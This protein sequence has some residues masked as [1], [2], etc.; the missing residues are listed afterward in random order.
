M[1]IATP[2]QT[3][4]LEEPSVSRTSNLCFRLISSYSFS[5]FRLSCQT[6]TYSPGISSA[7]PKPTVRKGPQH[8]LFT[9]IF[10]DLK[11]NFM[12]TEVTYFNGK[13]PNEFLSQNCNSSAIYALMQDLQAKAQGQHQPNHKP[14]L[15]ASTTCFTLI[16]LY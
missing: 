11:S 12:K 1:P 10:S 6:T 3:A 14:A 5:E 2:E 4:A 7:A 16:L 8:L 9:L 15:Q 13:L